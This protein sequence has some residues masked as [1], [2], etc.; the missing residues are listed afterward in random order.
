MILSKWPHAGSVNWRG[1][2]RDIKI[3]Q[4]KS[5]LPGY[6]RYFEA[7][8]SAKKL[9]RKIKQDISLKIKN[10]IIQIGL[11]DQCDETSKRELLQILHK[12]DPWRKGPFELFGTPLDAEWRSDL[13]WERL[14]KHTG[15]L[16]GKSILDIGCNNGYFLF[17][18]AK[19]KPRYL[20]G[21]D[22]VIPYKCQFEF[23]NTFTNLPNTEFGLFGVNE[24]KHFEKTF[25]VIFCLG[26][27]YHHPDPVGVLKTIFKCLKPGGM[28][29]IESQGINADGSYFLFPETKYLGAPGHW[30]LPS[31][32][33]LEN[34]V[35]RS[36]F[37]YVDTFFET[38]LSSEEQRRSPFSPHESLTDFLN[39]EDPNKTIEGY[40]APWRFYLKARRVRIRR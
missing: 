38:K 2:N 19:Q 4:Q 34:I 26:I 10:G 36:G 16:Q 24:L 6:Q 30:F 32:T 33:A 37:Q 14:R 20:L 9:K 13:K 22:P 40:P 29:I 18:M 12:M 17:H 39:P 21:I 25:D 28:I 11:A 27:I 7:L 5:K 8:A 35:R 1:L 3:F 15:P 23:M 31:K